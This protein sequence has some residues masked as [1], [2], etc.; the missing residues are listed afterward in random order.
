MTT[1]CNV[2][3]WMGIERKNGTREK[4]VKSKQSFYKLEIVPIQFLSFHKCT[5]V[6]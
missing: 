4:L 1:K 3:S 2:E 5:M 6:I